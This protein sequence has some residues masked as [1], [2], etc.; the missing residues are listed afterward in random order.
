MISEWEE[1]LPSHIRLAYL[2]SLGEVKLRLTGFGSNLDSLASEVETQI[3]RLLPLISNYVY[4]YNDDILPAAIGHLLI[5]QGK[6]VAL[7][8]SCT[9][10]YVSHLITSISGS[11]DYFNGGIIPYHNKFKEAVLGV[12]TEVLTREGAVSEGT[13]KEMATHVRKKFKADFGLSSSGIAGPG[14]DQKKS[15]WAWYGL[16]AMTDRCA[17]PGNYS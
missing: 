16:P 6:T 14:G 3:E 9:G 5:Q 8:E 1:A 13:V 15:Q 7:A 17:V 10:G 4:G 2:P 11:S 12:S